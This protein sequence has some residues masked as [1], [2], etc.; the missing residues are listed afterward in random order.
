MRGFAREWH[1]RSRVVAVGFPRG[2][3]LEGER[4]DF[5]A[6]ALEAQRG[7]VPIQN[8]RLHVVARRFQRDADLRALHG[9]HGAAA[10][11]VVVHEDGAPRAAGAR[12]SR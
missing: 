4:G 2:T 11:E 9:Q 12:C 6:A 1:D 8:A 5:L 7:V 3:D 10:L